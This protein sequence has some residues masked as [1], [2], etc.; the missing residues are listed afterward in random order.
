MFKDLYFFFYLWFGYFL[1][2]D[3]TFVQSSWLNYTRPS[4]ASSTKCW[5]CLI[6]YFYWLMFD[7]AGQSHR[8]ILFNYL[9]DYFLWLISWQRKGVVTRNRG[10]TCWQQGC[11]FQVV[12]TSCMGAWSA[13]REEAG[14]RWWEEEWRG[15]PTKCSTLATVVLPL[16]TASHPP[17]LC[18]P[19]NVHLFVK[20]LVR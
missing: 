6:N 18:A 3:H 20:A 2:L 1:W 10:Q 16:P 7:A 13:E 14:P 8:L 15:G 5:A 9:V 11:V 12:T 4:I 19:G 17:P